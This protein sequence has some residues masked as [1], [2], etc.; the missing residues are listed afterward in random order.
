MKS[1]TQR[2]RSGTAIIF[3][4]RFFPA[5]IFVCAGVL[6]ISL[7]SAETGQSGVG[8]NTTEKTVEQIVQKAAEEVEQVEFKIS[9]LN[10]QQLAT[11]PKTEG[12]RFNIYS[13]RTCKTNRN[14]TWTFE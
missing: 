10:P 9:E 5:L 8:E 6:P 2:S 1:K 4:K 14:I 3:L 13:G 11:I 7:G 12:T